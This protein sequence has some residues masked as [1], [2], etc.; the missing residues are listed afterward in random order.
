MNDNQWGE[1]APKVYAGLVGGW[2][3]RDGGVK[4]A[5]NADA[6][7]FVCSTPVCDFFYL[8]IAVKHTKIDVACSSSAASQHTC[9]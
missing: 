5:V 6:M 2:C 1:L 4:L 3:P 7:A 9:H 8:L